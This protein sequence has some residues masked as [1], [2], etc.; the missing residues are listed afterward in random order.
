MGMLR[1]S[2]VF[3]CYP[4]LNCLTNGGWW[5]VR[6]QEKRLKLLSNI[7]VYIT[8]IW[9]GSM[10]RGLAWSDDSGAFVVM[11]TRQ[12]NLAVALFGI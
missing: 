10:T 6:L 1:P 3:P 8:A 11:V 4:V 9:V 7:S 12:P 2:S 5:L